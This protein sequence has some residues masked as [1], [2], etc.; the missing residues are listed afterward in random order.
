VLV[1]ADGRV[2]ER[3]THES[4][5]ASSSSAYS[6]LWTWTGQAPVPS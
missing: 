4:L 6:S 1:V 3:G 5:L 2:V